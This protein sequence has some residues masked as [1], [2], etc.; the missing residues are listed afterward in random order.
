MNQEKIIIGGEESG[1]L[2][3]IMHIPERDGIFNGMLLL[4]IMAVRKM[5]IKELSDE[6]DE[7]FGLHRFLRRDVRVTE[8]AKK[9]ILNAC[10]RKP[11]KIGRFN[12][13]KIE[14][15]DGFKFF[16]DGG[17]LLIR[18]SGTEPLLRFYAEANSIRKVNELIDEALK[19]H[20]K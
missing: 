3:T 11:K 12:V 8:Q 2:G 20:K 1:G 19:I 18:A 10:K 7:E 16:V 15:K 4:E 17:W 13:K 6:L 14:T 9:Q 5:S